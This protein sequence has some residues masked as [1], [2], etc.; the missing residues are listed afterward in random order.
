MQYLA[1][2]HIIAIACIHPMQLFA[3][4][5]CARSSNEFLLIYTTVRDTIC[6]SVKWSGM[7]NLNSAETLKKFIR[8]LREGIYITNAL[9]DIIDCNPAFLEMFGVQSLE[10]LK[11]YKVEHLLRDP[12]KRDIELRILE[13]EGA[14]REF[15]LEIRRPDGQERIV[16]DTAY[17]VQDSLSGEVLYHGILVDITDRKHL[18][19]QLREQVI[20]DP[21]T[22]CYNRHHLAEIFAECGKETTSWGVIVADVDHFKEFNDLHGHIYGDRILAQ[23]G[24]FLTQEVRLEDKVFRIGGDEFMVYLPGCNL[25]ETSEVTNR[26]RRKGPAAAPVSITL[27]YG[28]REDQ[29]SLEETIRRA[30]QQL[31][32][33]RVQERHLQFRRAPQEAAIQ[34][35]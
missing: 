14:V 20:R 30:D 5:R 12:Q 3:G 22:G 23:L 4:D 16:L 6:R 10:E 27:G 7:R 28:V 33:I 2:A 35:P 34:G 17:R 15:E 8:N 29:E 24:R 32:H 31:I 11:G 9:G 18:E 19:R 21:L 1:P 13:K 26:F 25:R